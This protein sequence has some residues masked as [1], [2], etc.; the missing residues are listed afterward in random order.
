MDADKRRPGGLARGCKECTPGFGRVFLFACRAVRAAAGCR[1]RVIVTPIS[2]TRPGASRRQESR[3]LL[4]TVG[5]GIDR[6]AL[7]LSVTS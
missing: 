4:R 5:C 1:D 7:L 6:K 3:L 2:G